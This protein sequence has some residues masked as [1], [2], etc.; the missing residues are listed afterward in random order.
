MR[1]SLFFGIGSA[2]SIFIS[3]CS[4]S[5]NTQSETGIPAA[6]SD[7]PAF[8]TQLYG[9]DF[10]YVE[11]DSLRLNTLPLLE[12][13]ADVFMSANDFENLEIRGV[14]R[15]YTVTSDKQWIFVDGNN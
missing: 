3:S 9:T 4:P 13:A 14:Y 10:T 5:P 12:I 15:L 8:L 2:I 6:P 11:Y 7:P 1:N